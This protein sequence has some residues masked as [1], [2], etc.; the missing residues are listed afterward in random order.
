MRMVG[1][2][3]V[4]VQWIVFLLTGIFLVACDHKSGVA[5]QRQ[6]VPFERTDECHLCGM[7][8]SSFPGPRGELFE[9]EVQEVR[10]F[11]STRDLFAYYLQPENTHRVQ[12]IYVHD[13]GQSPWDKPDDRY[14]I[15]A[16]EAW[17]V[18]NHQLSGAMGPTLASFKEQGAA[19]AFSNTNGGSVI[20]FSDISLAML[21][22][23]GEA[24]LEKSPESAQI[25]TEQQG[26][27]GDVPDGHQH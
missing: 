26:A 24:T 19:Q 16:R 1:V 25:D 17:Y 14:L 10:K 5:Q 4:S 22:H 9:H 20:R 21:T 27:V 15:N 6:P 8:I 18:I 13:M 2:R 7:A 23:L 11:C 3:K 12:E